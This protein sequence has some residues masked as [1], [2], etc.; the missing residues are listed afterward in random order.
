MGDDLSRSVC[1]SNWSDK[2]LHQAL[3]M[4]GCRYLL[5]IE[6]YAYKNSF[7]I[8]AKKFITKSASVLR[9]IKFCRT[10]DLYFF[11]LYY[12]FKEKTAGQTQLIY[13]QHIIAFFP[14]N[15]GFKAIVLITFY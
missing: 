1:H 15:F 13:S 3:K 10:V 6:V 14:V 4:L 12:C 2:L 5:T 7:I 9:S 11:Y 8:I